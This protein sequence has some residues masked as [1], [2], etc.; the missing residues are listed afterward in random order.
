MKRTPPGSAATAGPPV[1]AASGEFA[2]TTAA[3]GDGGSDE[4]GGVSG[5]DAR[6]DGGEGAGALAVEMA[7]TRHTVEVV[8]EEEELKDVLNMRRPAE[9]GGWGPKRVSSEC[10]GPFRVKFCAS[11]PL[12]QN[13]VWRLN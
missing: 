11:L 12:R 1:A 7:S 13:A 10:H 4:A 8:Q 2:S 9:V 3:D 5:S 6:G